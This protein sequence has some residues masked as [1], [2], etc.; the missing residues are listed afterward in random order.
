MLERAHQNLC[1]PS[2]EQLSSVL[3]SQGCRP[4]LC[5]AMH[6]M[7]CPA[8]I[9]CQKPKIARPSTFK[10]ALDFNDQVF[11]DGISWTSKGGHNFHVYHLIDQATNFHVAIPA[12]NRTAEHAIV[13]V[14]GAWFNWAGPPNSLVMGSATEFTSEVLQDF[15]QKYDVRDIVEDVNVMDKSC[16]RC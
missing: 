16:Q 5:Q 9:S 6:D 12:P 3:R 8:R 15:L 7:K 14:S 2:A 10:D 1:H 11:I 4:E 13:K